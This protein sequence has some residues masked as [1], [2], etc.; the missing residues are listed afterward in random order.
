MLR[1]YRFYDT[2][3]YYNVIENKRESADNSSLHTIKDMLLSIIRRLD[4]LAINYSR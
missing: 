3:L 4:A 2:I 1:R